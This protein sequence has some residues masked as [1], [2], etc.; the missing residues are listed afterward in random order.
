MIASAR[1]AGV[2]SGKERMGSGGVGWLDSGGSSRA[3]G[4]RGGWDP[5]G[6]IRLA[7]RVGH[8]NAGGG[9]RQSAGRK[10][11]RHYLLMAKFIFPNYTSCR[12]LNKLSRRW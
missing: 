7:G 4:V 8:G 3:G 2:S 1:R 10:D 9:G 5:E 12:S 6:W 11:T